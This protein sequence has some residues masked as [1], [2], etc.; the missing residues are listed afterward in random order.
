MA[1]RRPALDQWFSLDRI[2]PVH[3]LVRLGLGPPC[4]DDTGYTCCDSLVV[5]NPTWFFPRTTNPASETK[6][7]F[8]TGS[9]KNRN[10]NQ[11]KE[12]LM[13]FFVFYFLTREEVKAGERRTR[14]RKEKSLIM[15]KNRMSFFEF[16]AFMKMH[17]IISWPQ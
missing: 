13:E 4:T 7:P 16:M 9:I 10:Q 15:V 11:T 3:G 14:W 17:A 2:G 1:E 5:S 8:L 6:K 12:K